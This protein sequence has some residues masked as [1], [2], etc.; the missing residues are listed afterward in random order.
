MALKDL[1][2]GVVGLGPHFRETLLPA[3]VAQEGIVLSGFCDRSHEKLQWARKR[4]A[5]AAFVPGVADS[6]FWN[7][8]DCVVCCSWPG[9]HEQVLN[10]AIDH[11]KHCFCEKPAAANAAA[12]D[13]IINRRRQNFTKI[14]IKV[15]H[16]FR[17]MG[18]A[19]RFIDLVTQGVCTCLDVTYLGSG[20]NGS[21]WDMIPRRAFSLTH[22]THAIDFVTA[23][24]GKIEKVQSVAW[25]N[26]EVTDTVNA[27]FE[28]ERCEF[29]NLFATNAAPAFTCKASAVL[30]TGALVHLDSLRNVSITGQTPQEKRSG[31]LWKERDLGTTPQNDGYMDELK[32]FFAEVR[33]E[34]HSRLPG[35]THAKHVLEMIEEIEG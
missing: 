15:G 22:L 21:R 31:L 20:P 8:I 13:A 14:V 7:A 34:A 18:G 27:V 35:L 11:N 16:T 24:V 32:D 26:T 1:R 2:V 28:T 12:L 17:Y 3:L 23:C 10:L 4:F 29:A 9:I 33:G 19:S 5:R 30:K 6:R 25:S